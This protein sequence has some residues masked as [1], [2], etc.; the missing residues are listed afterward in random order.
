M[1]TLLLSICVVGVALPAHADHP[2]YT[3]TRELKLDVKP[4]PRVRPVHPAT[5][6]HQPTVTATDIL[7]IEEAA[8]PIHREQEVILAGLV[9]DT[10]D[11]DPDKPDL[12]FRLAEHYARELRLWRLKATALEISAGE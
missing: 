1:R 12:L 3:R 5:A 10:P 7:A 9:R 11:G 6:P 2:R 4:A 8:E